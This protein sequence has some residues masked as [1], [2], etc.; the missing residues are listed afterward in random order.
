MTVSGRRIPVSF[1]FGDDFF[2]LFDGTLR[3]VCLT[4]LLDESIDK[5]IH[6]VFQGIRSRLGISSTSGVEMFLRWVPQKTITKVDGDLYDAES[7]TLRTPFTVRG[8]GF[9]ST[10]EMHVL[11]VKHR[12]L[13]FAMGRKGGHTNGLTSPVSLLVDDVLWLIYKHL[14]L[15]QR[16]KK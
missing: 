4:C 2:A 6:N 15:F 7:R 11:L 14:T 10:R 12:F 3:N 5:S 9:M 13:Y 8:D 1:A 16:V